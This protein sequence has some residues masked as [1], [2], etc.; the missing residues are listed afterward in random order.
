V[1]YEDSGNCRITLFLSKKI[2][3]IQDGDVY[4]DKTQAEQEKRIE[5]NCLNNSQING[6]RNS[7]K[8]QHLFF[9]SAYATH[10]E[11]IFRK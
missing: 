10:S 4:Q 11:S 1:T 9:S 5:I 6:G 2:F 8:Q 7:K 3:K